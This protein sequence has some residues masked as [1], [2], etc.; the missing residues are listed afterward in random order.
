M[1]TYVLSFADSIKHVPEHPERTAMRPLE[2]DVAIA[3]IL[4]LAA[5][6]QMGKERD[7]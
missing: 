3:F 5:L 2:W 1:K 7:P 6:A 4:V